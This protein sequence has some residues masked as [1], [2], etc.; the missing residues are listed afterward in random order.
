MSSE[1]ILL[2]RKVDFVIFGGTGD[3]SRNKLL[4]A[5][6]SLYKKKK[7][8]FKKIFLLGRNRKKFENIKEKFKDEFSN[9]LEFIEFYV[10]KEEYYKKLGKFL[11][12]GNIKIF[13]LALPPDRFSYALEGIGKFLNF[14]DKRIVIEKPYGLNYEDAENLNSIIGRY[15]SEEEIFRIDHFLG[16][17]QVQNIVSFKFSNFVI[18][19]IF[20]KNFIEKVEIRALEKVGVEEREA[21]YEK[22][23][24][25]RDM[26]QNHLLML[27]A[28]TCMDI[29]ASKEEFQKDRERVLKYVR[30][31][32]KEEVKKL[33]SKGKY[34][35]YKGSAETYVKGV[36]FIDN[37]KW[38]GVP[39]FVE[40]GKRFPEK[41]T[42][43]N[44][45]FKEV[46]KISE[47]FFNCGIE[48]NVLRFKLAPSVGVEMKVNLISPLGFTACYERRSWDINL[49]EVLGEIPSPY[50]SLLI[51]IIK[52]DRT[53]FIGKNEVLILWK[54]VEPI[55]EAFKEMESFVY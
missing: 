32:K 39:F 6:E 13:Y 44:V 41:I 29:P 49:E 2:K 38:N 28:L 24:A 11:E 22:V 23:G 30:I 36:F 8:K 5:L 16:K 1:D 31:F 33:F 42:E 15:F 26:V 55:L 9:L 10:E 51:D 14:E 3:L 17:A 12:K 52:G 27:L 54:I 53:L 21:Y 25:L 48:R 7:I 4:P 46:P 34:R 19:E 35:E 18:S 43:I 20:N 47:K 45:Y 40:T 50:E 37:E